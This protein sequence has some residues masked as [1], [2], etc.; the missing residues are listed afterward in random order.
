VD[1]VFEHRILRRTFAPNWDKII[2]GWRKLHNEELH[3]MYSSQIKIR[4]V[5]SKRI[6]WAEHV[7][8]IGGRRC[9]CCVLVVKT[10]RKQTTRNT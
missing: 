7:A 1:L 3:N 4:I 6:I 10:R 2:G 8:P 9:A 5:K